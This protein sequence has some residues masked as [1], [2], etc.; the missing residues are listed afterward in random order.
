MF[1]KRT[2]NIP[3]WVKQFYWKGQNFNKD[4]LHLYDCQLYEIRTL[5][6]EGCFW[7]WRSVGKTYSSISHRCNINHAFILGMAGKYGLC[8][9]CCLVSINW[10]DFVSPSFYEMSVVYNCTNFAS[11]LLMLANIFDMHLFTCCLW[12]PLLLQLQLYLYNPQMYISSLLSNPTREFLTYPVAI[13]E[14]P[15]L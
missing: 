6:L 14:H 5:N 13:W 2:W 12:L 8:A 15:Q 9:A 11:L 7:M 10:F 4:Q 3:K 1:W